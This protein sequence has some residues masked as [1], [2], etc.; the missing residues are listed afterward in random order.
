MQS[1]LQEI[2]PTNETQVPGN[3]VAH[4]ALYAVSRTLYDCMYC[5]GLCMTAPP[6]SCTPGA[7]SRCSRWWAGRGAGRGPG[8]PP[9]C[10]HSSSAATPCPCCVPP[11]P[12]SP[13]PHSAPSPCQVSCSCWRHLAVMF[14]TY[15]SCMQKCRK[16][17]SQLVFSVLVTVLEAGHCRQGF[18]AQTIQVYNS[19]MH[20]IITINS[21]VPI[22]P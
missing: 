22:W 13:A 16:N 7:R 2:P 6:P 1:Q 15:W 11:S 3:C 10:G 12:C 9:P 4:C 18:C 19:E 20:F 8:W 17:P 21:L 14:R 5:P